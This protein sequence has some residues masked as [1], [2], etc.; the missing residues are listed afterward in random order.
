MP[1][2]KVSRGSFEVG[3]VVAVPLGNG[4]CGAICVVEVHAGTPA[5]RSINF[6]VVEGSWDTTPTAVAKPEPMEH[7][8]AKAGLLPGMDHVWK[9][10]FS[11]PAPADFVVAGRVELS[12][13]DVGRY[14]GSQGTMVF[15]DAEELRSTLL[16]TWRERFD[17]AALQAEREERAAREDQAEA[18]R[19]SERTANNTLPKMLG[20]RPFAHWRGHWGARVVKAVHTAFRTATQDLIDLGETATRTKKAAVFARLMVELN[21][22]YDRE[23]CIETGEAE[24]L[25]T[26][27][28]ELGRLVGLDNT[29]ERLTGR[30]EW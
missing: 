29:D 14:T 9:G 18:R 17:Q 16:E 6:F 23:G 26:R 30:R 5:K 4:R 25:V 15:Q 3:D 22:L 7:P 8:Y 13:A 20:E 12:A 11:G 28:E 10:W 2:A 21:A 24:E 27:I 19:A 1:K